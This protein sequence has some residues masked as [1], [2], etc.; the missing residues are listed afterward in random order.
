MININLL[1]KNL[2]R[3]REPGYWAAIAILFPLLVFGTLAFIQFSAFQQENTLK[4]DITFKESEVRRLQPALD[5]QNELNRRQAQLNELFAIKEAVEQ[6]NIALSE[7]LFGMLETLPPPTGNGQPRI[8]FNQLSLQALDSAA[9]QQR[10]NSNLYEG[11]VP[12]AEITLQGQALNL[13]SLTAYVQELQDSPFFGV[14]FQNASREED[15]GV[16]Q[17]S[18][19]VGALS[20]GGSER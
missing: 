13:E 5:R 8:A 6:G 4:A 11:G 3:R 17:F 2:R 12:Q 18:L 7:Q 10:A 15:T 14:S 16:Y 19:S 20:G 9:G 1:P